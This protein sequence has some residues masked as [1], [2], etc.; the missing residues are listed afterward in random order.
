VA[1]ALRVI[2]SGPYKDIL[3]P[4]REVTADEQAILDALVRDALEQF[5]QAVADGRHLSQET[6]RQIADGRVFSGAQAQ[7]LGFAGAT[8]DLRAGDPAGYS[9]TTR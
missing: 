2:K 1:G 6:V 5:V 9:I 3:S 8:G 7:Q 4:S